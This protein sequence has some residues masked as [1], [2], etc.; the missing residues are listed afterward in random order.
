MEGTG[1]REAEILTTNNTDERGSEIGAET[2]KQRKAYKKCVKHNTAK[3][4]FSKWHSRSRLRWIK[5]N[6]GGSWTRP[7]PGP[8]PQE[9]GCCARPMEASEVD[10][11]NQVGRYR[12]IK[13]IRSH[14]I[15]SD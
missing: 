14:P 9:R 8:L 2:H 10:E 4:L 3:T 15:T 5:A 7:H 13:M 11:G 12:S 1:N 6:H